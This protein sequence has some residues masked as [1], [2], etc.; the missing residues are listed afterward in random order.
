MSNKRVVVIEGED[1][2]PEAVRPTIEMINQLGLDIEWIYP[3]VGL[4]GEELHG[5]TFPDEAK[6]A[7]DESDTTLFGATS[8]R[9]TRALFYLRWGKETFANVRPCRWVPGYKSPLARPED[10]DLVIVR[11]NLEDLYLMVEGELEDLRPVNLYSRTREM[12]LS[13]MGKGRYAVKVITEFE[14]E[15][16]ARFSFELARRRK[17]QGRPGK[18]TVACKYNM[19][20]LSD[21]FFRKTTEMVSESYPDIE[22]ESMI[23]DNFAHNLAVR[24]RDFDVILM[25]NLYGDILSDAAGGLIGGL[26]L[27]C[28]G[29]YGEN[30]AYFESAHGTAPDITGKNIINPTAT[31]LSAAMMLQYLGFGEQ[32]K[33]VEKAIEEV[34]AEGRYLT[35]DQGGKSSTYDFTQAVIDLL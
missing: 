32:S 12:L 21:G 5:T 22:F 14:T 20:P 24:P 34:Y 1:A 30:Y 4:K 10:I 28:S 23:I 7:I 16:V 17:N 9:S 31:M 33:Q 2:S 26:G 27:A 8:G 29:C 19:L 25:P 15:R 6:R 13:E 35:P 3:P 18:V 11:E